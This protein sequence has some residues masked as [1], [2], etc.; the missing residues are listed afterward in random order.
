MKGLAC[1]IEAKCKNEPEKFLLFTD[2]SRNVSSHKRGDL[3]TL[4][5]DNLETEAGELCDPVH[6]K[7]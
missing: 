5:A 6:G 3:S 2:F 4:R 7:F 1:I